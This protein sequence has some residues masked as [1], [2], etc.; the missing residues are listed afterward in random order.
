M[1]LHLCFISALALASESRQPPNI[2]FILADDLGFNDIGYHNSEIK[3]PVLDKLAEEGVTLENYY[4]QP[5]CTPT[6]S[7][8]LTGRYQI[9]TGLQHGI[10]WNAQPNCVPLEDITIAQKLKNSGYKT[11]A[12]GKWH[13][14]YYMK[15]CT[16]TYRGFDSFFGYLTGA[17][18]YE[19]HVSMGGYSSLPYFFW[20]GYDFWRNETVSTNEKGN[21]ST[22]LF[23]KEAQKIVKEHDKGSPLFL[24][25]AFQAVHMP[26][27]VP[28]KYLKQYQHIKDRNRRIYSGMVSAMD[29][30]VGNVTRTL[31]QRG[32]WNNTIIIF[33]TDN[34]G[35]VNFGGNNWPLKG[36]KGGLWEGGMR[37]VGFVNSPLLQNPARISR[38]MLHVS[39]W[40]P[41]LV[42][43]AGGDLNGTRPL[44]GYD[45]WETINTGTA[46]PRTEILHN[47]DPV[48]TPW[49]P[50]L[51]YKWC[52]QAALRVGDWKLL[53]GCPGDP[54]W[55]PPPSS[56]L[57]VE[58]IPDFEYGKEKIY[59]FNIAND[60]EERHE[61]SAQYPEKV[62]ELLG[63]LQ[64]YNSTA[65]PVRYPPPDPAAN[66]AIHDGIWVPW[67][68][69]TML[70]N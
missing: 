67:K 28:D 48:E 46:S 47:I 9:H 41:T 25:L 11:H 5:I 69:K 51:K 19:S 50:S 40:F 68:G 56:D 65:V 52:P 54:N 24:Y 59:L 17:E 3:T 57:E 16:P 62:G 53:T 60:P 27:Q 61:L 13:N 21:Y 44:D 58:D 55:Y 8:L 26:L 20:S 12:V 32:F 36:Y 38:E 42:S 1:L 70:N 18:D 15:E 49:F 4:V 39:D 64:V 63:R 66:P 2:V 10:I 37:G 31:K 43:L 35:D 22:I 45:I 23:A 34:G 30:A 7:T 6:R 33:S 14:G 29:E